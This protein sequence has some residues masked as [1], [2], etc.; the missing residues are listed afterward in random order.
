MIHFLA[1]TFQSR[2]GLSACALG[3]LQMKWDKRQ[4]VGV[5]ERGCISYSFPVKIPDKAIC[6][7]CHMLDMS[8]AGRAWQKR[9]TAGLKRPAG[10]ARKSAAEMGTEAV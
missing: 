6:Q 1:S 3:N 2:F 7:H 4:T 8:A 5:V 10:P 9:G